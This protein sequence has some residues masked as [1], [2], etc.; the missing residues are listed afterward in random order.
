MGE[1]AGREGE[2]EGGRRG[3]RRRSGSACLPDL[4][5]GGK[6]ARRDLPGAGIGSGLLAAGLEGAVPPRREGGSGMGW[7]GT[8]R[9]LQE[10]GG[11][12]EAA[13][14]ACGVGGE[15][16]KSQPLRGLAGCGVGGH[17]AGRG[18]GDDY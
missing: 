9:K 17:W 4:R 10:G 12:H 18:R 8:E 6:E 13:A 16:S 2:G 11:E 3:G 5:A 14:A 15:G 7:N 1:K